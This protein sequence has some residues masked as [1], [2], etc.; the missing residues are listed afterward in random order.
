MKLLGFV[1]SGVADVQGAGVA[2][3]AVGLALAAVREPA[4]LAGTVV[5]GGAR[6]VCT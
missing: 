1:Q 3:D 4:G 5:D 2:A 6:E